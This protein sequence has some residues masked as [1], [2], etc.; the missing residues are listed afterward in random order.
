MDE[1]ECSSMEEEKHEIQIVR[2]DAKRALV[3]TKLK[4]SSYGWIKLRGS[5]VQKKIVEIS[6]I[7]QFVSVGT[8]VTWREDHRKIG[9]KISPMFSYRLTGTCCSSLS[10]MLGSQIRIRCSYKKEESTGFL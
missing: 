7:G 6:E 2:V 10:R 5:S 9:E 4:L 1:T 3:E 8:T